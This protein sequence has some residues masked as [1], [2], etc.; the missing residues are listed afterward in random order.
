MIDGLQP[1]NQTDL[2]EYES[3]MREAIPQIVEDQWRREVLAAEARKRTMH[4][5]RS[6]TIEM[7]VK[8]RTATR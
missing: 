7:D 8:R 3:A 5:R 2:A 4:R 1:V 6:C